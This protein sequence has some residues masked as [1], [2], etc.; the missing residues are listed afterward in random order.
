M[1]SRLLI[2]SPRRL[3]MRGLQYD[4]IIAYTDGCKI[5]QSEGRRP[6]AS[7][8]AALPGHPFRQSAS[9]QATGS[10]YAIPDP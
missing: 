8:L 4:T 7:P 3:P 6:E 1:K 5:S 9:I 2:Q 10:C